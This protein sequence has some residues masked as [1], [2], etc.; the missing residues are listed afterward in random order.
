M[1]DVVLIIVTL[2]FLIIASYCDLKTREVP[3]WLNYG[4]IFSAIGI[5]F[6][7]SFSEGWNLLISG[8]LGLGVFVALAY[9]LYYTHLW[10]G[11]D[12]KLL[13]GMGAVIGISYPFNTNSW[14]GFWFI[15]GLF[16]FGAI[17]GLIWMITVAFFKK[18]IFWNKFKKN[19]SEYKTYQLLLIIVSVFLLILGFFE[20]T[21]F[22]LAFFPLAFFYL[23]LFITSLESSCFLKKIKVNQLTEG[24]WL[25]E[26][27]IIKGKK[28]LENKTIDKK[29]LLQLK[30]MQV[31]GQ[32]TDVIIKEGIPFVPSF[33]FAYL[34]LF[35][36][37][38]IFT[39]FWSI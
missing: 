27:I 13:M 39:L 38:L 3:D 30:K 10:G 35:F 23:L 2:T 6:I 11:G 1:I 36:G 21:L 4:L 32:L 26:D 7:F 33:L 34:L 12:S 29:D 25:A 16:F 5:R 15:L 9:L 24:D 37:D 20:P 31:S 17:Y 19:V 22:P 8:I 14:N 18:N 28:I